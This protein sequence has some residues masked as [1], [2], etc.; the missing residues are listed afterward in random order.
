M[1]HCLEPCVQKT[2]ADCALA[3]IAMLS[4]LPYRLVSEAALRLAPTV[5]RKGLWTTQII[6][7]AKAVKFPLI[8]RRLK[9]I[10]LDEA[11]GL[12][13]MCRKAGPEQHCAVL[14]EGVLVNPGDG[15]VWSLDTYLAHRG[16]KVNG[17][18]EP[19]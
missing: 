6:A 17:F 19:V 13:T 1:P 2:E 16:W 11:T 3:A 12:V 9:S 4:G 10:E 15:F 7:I 14:F 8:R 5:H 18:L